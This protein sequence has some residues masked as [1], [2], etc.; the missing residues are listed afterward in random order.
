MSETTKTN[1]AV[2]QPE[3]PVDLRALVAQR[4]ET[5]MRRIHRQ[6]FCLDPQVQSQL[7]AARAEFAERFAQEAVLQQAA[8]DQRPNRKYA[9]SSKTRELSVLVDELTEKSRQVG[10]MGVFQNLTD[11]GTVI[12]GADGGFAKAREILLAA[13]VRWETADGEPIPDDVFGRGDL[14][15][16]MQPEVLEQGEWLPLAGKIMTESHSPIDRPT[17]PAR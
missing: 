16:L 17:L 11:P 12:D 5:R 9:A 7:D 10:A 8:Q 13:F 2:E 6:W 4:V 15:A 14:D 3:F 1:Q